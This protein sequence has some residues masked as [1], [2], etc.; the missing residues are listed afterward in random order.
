MVG[1]NVQGGDSEREDR[2]TSVQQQDDGIIV[3]RGLSFKRLPAWHD[4]DDED[5][6]CSVCE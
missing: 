3:E 6:R 5:I 4:E 1:W 2:A